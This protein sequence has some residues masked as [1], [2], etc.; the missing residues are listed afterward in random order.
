MQKCVLIHSICGY[1]GEWDKIGISRMKDDHDMARLLGERIR[2]IEG[3]ELLH[4]VQTN[5]V[6]MNVSGLGLNAEQFVD[7]AYRFGV[8]VESKGYNVIRLVTHRDI[9]RAK[10]AHTIECLKKIPNK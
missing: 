1:K 8:L 3:L 6:R 4:E 10:V 2:A 9:S 5:I 7:E